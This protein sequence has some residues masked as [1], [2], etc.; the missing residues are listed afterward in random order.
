MRILHTITVLTAAL[1]VTACMSKEKSHFVGECVNS[2]RAVSS[3]ECTFDK[4]TD[5]YGTREFMLNTYGDSTTDEFRA[6]ARRV[7]QECKN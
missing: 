2:G 3:C 7:V 5:K 1:A 4:L 6:D